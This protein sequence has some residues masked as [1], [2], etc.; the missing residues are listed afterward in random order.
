M[1]E[2]VW[3]DSFYEAATHEMKRLGANSVRRAAGLRDIEQWIADHT[4]EF[5]KNALGNAIA[6]FTAHVGPGAAI[7]RRQ[8]TQ[9]ELEHWNAVRQQVHE[10]YGL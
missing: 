10:H 1:S 6:N 5:V 7:G 3:T 8:A 9:E 2:S 4:R